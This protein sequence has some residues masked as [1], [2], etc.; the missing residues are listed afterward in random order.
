[1]AINNPPGE[2]HREQL[3]IH[4]EE[5]Q[6]ENAEIVVELNRVFGPGNFSVD[7]EGNVSCPQSDLEL[8]E[9]K[10]KARVEAEKR[11]REIHTQINEIKKSDPDAWRETIN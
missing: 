1:M 2:Q 4:A 11:L 7:Q 9:E 3:T 8:G 10:V 6:R 5:L